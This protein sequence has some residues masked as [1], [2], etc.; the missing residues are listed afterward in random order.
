[1]EEENQ[2]ITENKTDRKKGKRAQTTGRVHLPK[3]ETPAKDG[4]AKQAQTTGSQ[5]RERNRAGK[6]HGVETRKQK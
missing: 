2:V 1:M 3:H 4:G 6:D 5:E